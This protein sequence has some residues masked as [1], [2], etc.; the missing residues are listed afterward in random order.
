MYTCNGILFNHDP[1]R[2]ETFVT[3]ITAPW[4]ESNLAWKTNCAAKQTPNATGA[5]PNYVEMQ[6][7]M[8]ASARRIT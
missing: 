6:W 3:R 8:L 7:L 2:G 1:I 4:P 5:M